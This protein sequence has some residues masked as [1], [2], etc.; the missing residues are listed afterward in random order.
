[1][2]G[3]IALFVVFLWTDDLLTAVF[4]GLLAHIVLD[5]D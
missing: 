3:I 4:V 2:W 5:D 1:M